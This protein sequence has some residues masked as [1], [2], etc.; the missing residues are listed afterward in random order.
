VVTAVEI[1][2]LPEEAPDYLIGNRN[3]EGIRLRASPYTFPLL[4]AK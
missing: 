1:E 3:S 2:Q 4:D